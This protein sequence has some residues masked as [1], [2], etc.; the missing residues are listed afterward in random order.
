MARVL[1]FL[2]GFFHF[3]TR[4]F[5]IIDAHFYSLILYHNPLTD[6]D[7][8]WALL[9]T[10]FILYLPAVMG[11]PTLQTYYIF[12]KSHHDHEVIQLYYLKYLMQGGMTA[13]GALFELS[14]S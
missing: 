2:F 12:K 1:P 4:M 10:Q 7:A 6:F 9:R 5:V 8:L 13:L 11:I 3:W 14:H